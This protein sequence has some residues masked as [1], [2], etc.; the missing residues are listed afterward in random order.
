MDENALVENAFVYK[1]YQT[2][3]AN[4]MKNEKRS[5]RRKAE[6]IRDIDG[7]V[8]FEKSNGKKVLYTV[9]YS[10]C[11]GHCTDTVVEPL[12]VEFISCPHANINLH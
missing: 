11:E 4:C 8:Y 3:P 5:I 2:Y 7:E 6:K 9:R 10:A 1:K 12:F